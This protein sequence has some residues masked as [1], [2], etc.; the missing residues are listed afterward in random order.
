MRDFQQKS[1]SNAGKSRVYY[2]FSGPDA[3]M[4]TT[5]FP[6]SPSYVMV[7]LE[8]AGT[9][10][11]PKQMGRRDLSNFLP[12]VRQTVASELGRSFF[13]TRQMDRQFR[14]QVTDGLFQPI[15][16]LLVRTKHTILGFRYIRLD[17]GGRIIE[18]AADYHA[19]GRIGNK[20][21]EIDFRSDEDG[22]VHKLVYLTVNLSDEMLRDNAPFQSF[23]SGL[24]G[25]TTYL[26]ATSYML[27]KP[28]FSIARDQ[29]LSASSV[30]LQDDSGIPYR[31]FQAPAWR[32]EL[33]GDYVRPYGSFRWLEQEDLRK[34]YL[35][36]GPKTLGFRIGYGYGRVPSNLLIATRAE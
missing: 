25:A 7:G 17:D 18:R 2:P 30:I 29:I 9:L 31:S 24:K 6:H 1:L 10:P 20:G 28:E 21:V 13:I 23:V 35:T 16:E 11:T 8:P 27:H 3:L 4:P 32:V 34:A 19:P 14:G 5:F 26:K 15:V 36:N 22:S 33:Y 12:Q